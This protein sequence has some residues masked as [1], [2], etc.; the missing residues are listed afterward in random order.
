MYVY[1]NNDYLLTTCFIHS[2][3]FSYT[4]AMFTYKKFEDL[5]FQVFQAIC[6]NSDK[7]LSWYVVLADK[8]ING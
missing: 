2:L 8:Q 1:V 6:E 7:I 5:N 3:L 4:Q